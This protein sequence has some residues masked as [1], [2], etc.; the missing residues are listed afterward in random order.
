MEAA[1][2]LPDLEKEDLRILMAIEI[3]MKRSEYVKINN[4]KFYSR[5][6]MEETLFRLKKIHKLDLIIRDSSKSEVGYTLNSIAY[7]LLALHTLV[8]K[9]IISQLGP[10]IGKGK[11]SDV[12]SCMDDHENI[13]ALKIYRM[14]RTSFK[15]IKRL[16][17]L[18]GERSHHSW[19]YINR[20]AAKKEF[21]ALEKIYKLD[22]NTPKPI[23]YNRH[24]VVMSYLRGK[25]LVYYKHISNPEK[26]FNR[27]IKQMKI[28]YQKANMIHGDLGEFNVVLD[29]KGNIL[30]IDWLQWISSDHPNATSILERDIR[31]VC[32]YFQK[33]YKVKSDL[34]Q[35][36][37]SFKK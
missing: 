33:K 2:L 12:Y 30:I 21:E 23:G 28:I 15:S 6:K 26:I 22:L 7:D 1:K 10:L 36:L 25:E 29:E 18:I 16:R 4:I 24:I 11:E 35:I 20:L 8:E 37:A 17:D 32:N 34:N 31:N 9:N 5:Y 27:I 3:G 13:F 14:G 19:L